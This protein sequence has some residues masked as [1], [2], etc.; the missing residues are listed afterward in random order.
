LAVAISTDGID[1]KQI[2]TLEHE[3]AAGQ[4][5]YPA[6]IQTLDGLVHITYTYHRLSIKHVVLDPK[7]LK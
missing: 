2:M 6:V 3:D 1:W 5:S 7:G 4:N